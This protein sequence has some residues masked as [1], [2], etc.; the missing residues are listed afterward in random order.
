ML[1]GK[2]FL[3]IILARAGSKRLPNKNSLPLA[4]KPLVQWTIDAAKSSSFIDSIVVSSDDCGILELARELNVIALDRP[5]NLATDIASSADCVVHVIENLPQRFD[6]LVLLQPTSPLRTTND[7]DQAIT[8]IINLR[9]ESITSVSETEHNPLWSNTLP[10]DGSLTNFI[11][12]EIKNK[13]SQDLPT[14]YRLNGATYI[15][16]IKAFLKNRQFIQAKGY[17]QKMPQERSIDIDTKLDFLLVKS[18]MESR[19]T[20]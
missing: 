12:S 4:G 11:S 2:S 20:N 5:A 16:N 8:M 1:N 3:A 19:L 15:V 9:C 18:V 14:Y 17:A 10:D 13:R 7:I 6:Y